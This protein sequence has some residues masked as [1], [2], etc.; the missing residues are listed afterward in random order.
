LEKYDQ[1][2][3]QKICANEALKLQRAVNNENFALHVHLKRYE[4]DGSR[5]KYSINMRVEFPGRIVSISQDDW[6]WRTA[7]RKTFA[8]AKNKV[9]KMFKEK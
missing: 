9:Q 5:C 2:A 8:N 1:Q 6:D 4:K 7:V 3:L